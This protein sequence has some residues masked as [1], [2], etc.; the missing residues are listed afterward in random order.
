MLEVLVELGIGR[1]SAGVHVRNAMA[2]Q[3][4]YTV[5]VRKTVTKSALL[6][7][8]LFAGTRGR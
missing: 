7:L 6:A 3:L 1:V 8:T 4:R 2:F 5:A